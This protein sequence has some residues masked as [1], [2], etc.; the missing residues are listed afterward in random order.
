MIASPRGLREAPR[1]DRLVAGRGE[2][3]L[4]VTPV[5]QIPGQILLHSVQRDQHRVQRRTLALVAR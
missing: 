4:M 3:M 5:L 1:V 2:L